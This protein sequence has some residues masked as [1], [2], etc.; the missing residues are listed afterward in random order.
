[1]SLVFN[2]YVK[3]FRKISFVY[4]AILVVSYFLVFGQVETRIAWGQQVWSA[5][6]SVLQVPDSSSETV[7]HITINDITF[8]DVSRWAILAIIAP[9]L[10]DDV[11]PIYL[12]DVEDVRPIIADD[13]NFIF[14]TNITLYLGLARQSNGSNDEDNPS[15]IARPY[16]RENLMRIFN[17]NN[18]R[19]SNGSNDEDDQS[20]SNEPDFTQVYSRVVS[21]EPI[22][23]IK[24]ID[25]FW[26][27][28]A[29]WTAGP[30]QSIQEN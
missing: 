17:D 5:G 4:V 23:S 15:W 10:L 7:R 26:V 22:E 8:W 24:P 16:T 21:I 13:S 11:I 14:N 9:E 2:M 3:C 18:A 6:N 27:N 30:G 1:M 25:R 29:D 28:T 20:S 19:Q 12:Y